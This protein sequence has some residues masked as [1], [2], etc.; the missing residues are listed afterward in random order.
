MQI[1]FTH[2]GFDPWPSPAKQKA[3]YSIG[4]FALLYF[5]I[6]F[7]IASQPSSGLGL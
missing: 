5:E 2:A 1:T 3:Q 7:I 6:I 4:L